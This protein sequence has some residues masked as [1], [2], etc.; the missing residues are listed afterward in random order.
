[1]IIFLIVLP[2]IVEYNKHKNGT[3]IDRLKHSLMPL[4]F[5][6]GSAIAGFILFDIIPRICGQ[7][8]ENMFQ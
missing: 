8:I 3:K 7:A 1:M 5:C 6:I 4:L 2:G